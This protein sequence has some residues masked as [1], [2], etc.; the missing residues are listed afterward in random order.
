M[1]RAVFALTALAV[2]AFS[3]QNVEVNRFSLFPR[4]TVQGDFGNSSFGYFVLGDMR[5]SLSYEKK[6]ND[7]LVD[8]TARELWRTDL[9][10]GPSWNTKLG[11]KLPLSVKL[12]YHPMWN[13]SSDVVEKPYLRHSAE[14]QADLTQPVGKKVKLR[15]RIIA[16][17][18]FKGETGEDKALDNEI[19]TRL[20]A[21]GIFPVS[22]QF[23]LLLD[24]EIFLK[25]TADD[26]DLDGTELFHKNVVWAGGQWKPNP[27]LTMKLQY[28][29]TFTN[30]EQSD[31][32]TVE[33]T[34]PA[35]MV[36]A[37]VTIPKKKDESK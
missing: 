3:A 24:E 1:K 5:Y 4:L 20:L 12:L 29:H 18:W 7:K 9:T 2:S 6:S 13:N 36:H 17:D 14:I 22:K 15:Y 21:G 31:I 16:S 8:S 30:S 32:R 19:Y 25:P 11:D 35:V 27:V 28:V 34:D 23:Q 10:V 33:V 26:T 37:V